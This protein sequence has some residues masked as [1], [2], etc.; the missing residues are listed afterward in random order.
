MIREVVSNSAEKQ[1]KAKKRVSLYGEVFTGKREVKAMLD[2]IPKSETER[3]E[4]TFLE[5]S[6]G[7]GAFTVEILSRKLSA[8]LRDDPQHFERLSLVAVSSVYAIELLPD[9][10]AKAIQNMLAVWTGFITEH[11]ELDFTIIDRRRNDVLSLLDKNFVLGNTLTCLTLNNEPIRFYE[12][13]IDE[14]C[15]ITGEPHVFEAML[16]PSSGCLF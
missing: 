4:S 6:C 2:L 11:D 9:N 15:N 3:P 10:R 8:V 5:P 7:E 16:K 13:R 1:V 14:N 12:W